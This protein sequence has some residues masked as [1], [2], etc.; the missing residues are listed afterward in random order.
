MLK[1][2]SSRYPGLFLQQQGR[3]WCV[4]QRF[5]TV[6]TAA[7]VENMDYISRWWASWKNVLKTPVKPTC[8]KCNLC[9]RRKGE[10]MILVNFIHKILSQETPSRLTCCSAVGS[11]GAGRGHVSGGAAVLCVCPNCPAAPAQVGWVPDPVTAFPAPQE[12]GSAYGK[13][14][15]WIL[16]RGL[17]WVMCQEIDPLSGV[18]ASSRALRVTVLGE[19]SSAHFIICTWEFQ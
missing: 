17:L 12:Y 1:L 14:G 6:A 5:L 11:E 18:L 13:P 9:E 19:P 15:L 8:E 16:E 3:F 4:L 7:A 2:H 10:E